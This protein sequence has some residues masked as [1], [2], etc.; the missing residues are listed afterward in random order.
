MCTLLWH[1]F[2]AF[3]VLP[4]LPQGSDLGP[5]LF[6]K[7]LYQFNKNSP[8]GSQLETYGRRDWYDLPYIHTYIRIFL[9]IHKK[10]NV[11]IGCD[12]P[13]KQERSL[14][15]FKWKLKVSSLIKLSKL[16]S[17]FRLIIVVQ[18]LW[19]TSLINLKDEHYNYIKK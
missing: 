5:L 8:S 18:R 7:A 13:A 4:G 2:V 12:L 15:K 3:V 11:V 9:R 16:W 19:W 14:H 10:W 6:K 1:I 17:I